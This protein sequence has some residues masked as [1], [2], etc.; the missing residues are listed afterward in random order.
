MKN[1]NGKPS[2]GEI[3]VNWVKSTTIL[4]TPGQ[5]FNLY[6]KQ[7]ASHSNE[8]ASSDWLPTQQ[9][10]PVQACQSPLQRNTYAKF[11]CFHFRV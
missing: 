6:A 11:G 8:T 10:L 1:G 2:S 3:V 7:S 9:N 5:V 4:L